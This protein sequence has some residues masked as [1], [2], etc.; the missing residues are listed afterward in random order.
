M[1]EAIGHRQAS[2]LLSLHVMKTLVC[3]NYVASPTTSA[4]EPI[5]ERDHDILEYISGYLLNKLKHCPEAKYLGE[6]VTQTETSSLIA[7]KNRGGLT[8]PKQELV[9]LVVQM[10]TV[11]RDL[12]ERSVDRDLFHQKLSGTNFSTQFYGVVESVITS[13]ESKEIFFV[14]FCNLFFKVR[15][16]HKCRFMLEKNIQKNKTKRKTK[17]LRD[18]I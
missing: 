17:A 7:A 8:Q 13:L 2:S 16:H 12:P 10:E 9:D 11:F 15:A 5:G 1:T 6:P 4:V 18:S 14:D 3:R